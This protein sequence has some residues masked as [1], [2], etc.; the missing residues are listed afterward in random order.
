M[1]MNIDTLDLENIETSDLEKESK[2]DLSVLEDAK[3]YGIDLDTLENPIAVKEYSSIPS[4][5]SSSKEYKNLWHDFDVNLKDIINIFFESSERIIIIVSD[6]KVV[7]LNHTA[8]KL[9]DIKNVKA[10]AN[11]PF[12]SLVD[13]DEW[14]ILT[15]NIGEMLTSGKKQQVR[16]KSVKG[17]FVPTEV[18][19]IYLPDSEHFSFILVGE[20]KRNQVT[21][22][23][24]NLYDD[25]TGLPNFFLFED[26]VQMAVNNENYKDPGY[27]RNL[28]AVIGI[29]I[30]NIEDFRRLHL[31]EFALKKLAN[32]LVLSL[33]K[34]YTIARGLKY[35]FWV[36]IPNITNVYE[37][38]TEINKIIA[39]LQDGISDNF[40]THE[41]VTSI[42]YSTYPSPSHSAKKLMEQSILALK[43]AQSYSD[44][45]AIKYSQ[46]R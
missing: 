15:S 46:E 32:T 39:I 7:Y 18:Q 3:K 4:A 40:T 27:P 13:K 14:S 45:K 37:L 6:D 38:E 10:I 19:A 11:E 1:N 28:V 25:L 42:G 9:L 44:N 12:L 22:L 24:N 17:K 35:P 30:D 36:L 20:H 8:Q 41:L 16:F 21:G 31:E 33:K 23:F 34:S 29:S 2:P 5:E 26:R 43:E